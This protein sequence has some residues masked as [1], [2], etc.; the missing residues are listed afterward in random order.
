MKRHLVCL[1]IAPALVPMEVV[2][3]RLKMVT[4]V[5]HHEAIERSSVQLVFDIDYD[6]YLEWARLE[7]L[8]QGT[9]V[10]RE[11][12]FDV[13]VEAFLSSSGVLGLLLNDGRL[14]T[15]LTYRRRTVLVAA[16]ARGWREPR[17]NLTQM[18]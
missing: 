3:E 15:C 17:R 11:H 2:V 18:A 16:A 1:M 12:A 8:E 13:F 10:L 14:E 6:L 9:V 7:Y 5:A 4:D